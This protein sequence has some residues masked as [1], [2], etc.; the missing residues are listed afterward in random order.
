M[1]RRTQMPAREYILSNE[2]GDA[3]IQ[4]YEPI[5]GIETAYA[6]VHMDQF[7]FGKTEKEISQDYVGFH[8]CKEGRIEQEID[9]EFFYLMPGDCSIVI[10]DR[11]LKQFNLPM[12]HYHG[13]SIG[14][15]VTAASDYFSNTLKNAGI[16]MN[17]YQA[18]VALCGDHHSTILRSCASV[19]RIFED[20]Y[21]VKEAQREEYL[22]IKLLELLY[23][24]NHAE[25]SEFHFENTVVPRAQVSFVKRV[26][27]HI[28][29]NLNGKIAIRDLTQQFGVSDTYLQNS[30]RAVY[31]MPVISFI[32]AQKMQSAAQVLIHTE[33][34]VDDIAEEFGYI[35][36]SKF[37]AV[38][39]KI[40]G[41]SPSV[42]RKEHSK[43]RIL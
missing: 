7:D 38:F 14:I 9:Q 26:A 25:Q 21:A 34:S 42:Y 24:L 28:S 5:P 30:F 19:S 4:V 15:D 27:E 37:S 8:Y 33:R 16:Q 35:N 6:S 43:I 41:D 23:L 12:R 40:M 3:K 39:K 29:K 17:P 2:T 36:E 18:A 22:K 20:L 13:I 11:H 32:R 1:I 31:G 10:Q